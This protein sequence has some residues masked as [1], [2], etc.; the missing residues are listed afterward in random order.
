MDLWDLALRASSSSYKK[1]RVGDGEGE[2]GIEG[3]RERENG[4]RVC[5]VCPACVLRVSCVCPACVLRVSCVCHVYMY[6]LNT[7]PMSALL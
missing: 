5:C 3:E 1:E 7:W 4:L 2:R 6:V